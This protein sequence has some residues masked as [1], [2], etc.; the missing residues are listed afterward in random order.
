MD[1]TTLA[2]NLAWPITILIAW[3]AG[4]A[5]S[6]Y[7]KLPRISVY[8]L[9]GF[10]F[11]HT[12]PGLLPQASSN[13]MLLLAN[14][15]FGLI[16]FEAG[17]RFNLRW[18]RANYWLGVSSLS[19]A[20]LTFVAVYLF[21][22]LFNVSGTNALLLAALAMATSPATVVQVVN[23]QRSAGQVTERALHLSVWSCVWVVFAFKLIL[24]LLVFKTSGSLL[25][26]AYS[27]LLVLAAS[28]ALGAVFGLMVPALLRATAA[29]CSAS[30]SAD[31][32]CSGICCRWCCLYMSRRRWNGP[33]CW[34]GSSLVW[35]SL[36]CARFAK[37]RV[38][39]CLPGS[40]A[41]VGARAG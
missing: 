39:A 24:G 30:P 10:G 19:E 28:A 27:S 31:S 3:F 36:P 41:R 6:R 8:A 34:P 1:L 25:Q 7:L 12:Q 20:S 11:A 14:V 21:S 23:E 26:A 2:W 40:A 32:A 4:E 29:L 35:S 38:S 17:H 13:G 22:I 37:C 5:G 16:L 33:P 18:L 9:A 15:A